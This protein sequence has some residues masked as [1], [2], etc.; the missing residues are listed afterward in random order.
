MTSADEA[1]VEG[2]RGFLAPYAEIFAIPHAWRFS[3]AG[4][5]GRMPMS[6]YG[7]GAVLL[8]SAGTGRY[9]LAGSVAAAGSLGS[10]LC[11]PQVARL[12][13]RVGQHRVLLPL[14][15]VF[16]LSV[17]GLV[18]AVELR[19]P[20]WTLFA[21]GIAGGA[22]MPQTG[23]MSR[24]RWSALLAGSP[25]L[26]TA[27][28]VESVADEVCFVIGPAAAT[29]LATQVHPAAGLTFATV[30]CL[31]GS[32]WFSAQRSTEPPVVSAAPP[33]DAPP[34]DAQPVDAQPVA[35]PRQ[36]GHGRRAWLAAPTLAVLVPAY[37]FL[38]AQFVSIDLSTVDFAARAGHKPLAGFI[39]GT[40]ALGSATGGLWYG[41]R[42]WRAPA[43]QR[44]AVTLSM[45]VAGVC[46]FW[47]IPNLAVL[48]P[49]IFLC[50]LT[51]APSLIA[52]YSLVESTALPGRA[53]EAM[54]WL[55]TG[56]SVGVACGAT[57]A[58]FVLDSF[59]P[60]WGYAFAAFCGL[61]AVLIYLSGLRRMSAS[62]I[63]A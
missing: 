30:L 47:A 39:L 42:S 32:L 11:V 22:T 51:I 41:S 23:P 58:G 18:A 16:S 14:S 3:V 5:L 63:S 46:S 29:V 9:G 13:D 48:T 44:L 7:L 61:T 8:I 26:H 4:I 54:S 49:V 62:A 43:W 1:A 33:V 40:Y 28:S 6:M 35:R 24:A 57:V 50:G 21:C 25:R 37:L 36:E 10:A 56:I 2:P 38:G 53:T 45:T 27:F 52:G 31:S 59:G 20:D 60:S 12:V 34:V 19:A 17:I 55:S 15:L